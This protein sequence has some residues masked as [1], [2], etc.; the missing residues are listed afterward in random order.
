MGLQKTQNMIQ[1]S[2]LFK[3]C[4]ILSCTLEPTYTFT[5]TLNTR[6][7]NNNKYR[8]IPSGTEKTTTTNSFIVLEAK[9]N[10]KKSKN[11]TTA[12]QGFGKK[13]NINQK[14]SLTQIDDDSSTT[15]TNY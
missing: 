10:K 3:S 8:N 6:Y 15:N 2:T 1:L 14:T 11:N 5:T 13:Q 4:L 9:K 12:G 7:I